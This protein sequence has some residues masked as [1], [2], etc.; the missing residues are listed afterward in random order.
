MSTQTMGVQQVSVTVVKCEVIDEVSAE[1]EAVV[2][3][4]NDFLEN[5][6][7]VIPP[8]GGTAPL[9]DDAESTS[10][11]DAVYPYAWKASAAVTAEE[12]EDAAG[13]PPAPSFKATL[14]NSCGVALNL[15]AVGVSLAA[16]VVLGMLVSAALSSIFYGILGLLVLSI[17]CRV[18]AEDGSLHKASKFVRDQGIQ[19]VSAGL[20]KLGKFVWE[21]LPSMPH[22]PVVS[23][24]LCRRHA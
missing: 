16:A 19:T 14:M 2:D 17:V 1:T 6:T 7:V 23:R 24:L 20:C 11:T 12:L 22:I 5:T 15:V 13:L 4:F 9:P 8:S 21:R 3:I 10:R 18:T